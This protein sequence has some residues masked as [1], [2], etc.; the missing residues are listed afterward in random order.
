M[1]TK[2][3]GTTGSGKPKGR[4]DGRPRSLLQG[5]D[6]KR[7]YDDVASR[8][9]SGFLWSAKGKSNHGR[10]LAY[11]ARQSA[12]SAWCKSKRA[13]KKTAGIG[14]RSHGVLDK[15]ELTGRRNAQNPQRSSSRFSLP[16]RCRHCH[17]LCR[18]SLA[19]Q[20]RVHRASLPASGRV[21]A[22]KSGAIVSS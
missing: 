21:A 16:P 18:S 11:I 2:D 19:W 1:R 15:A 22:P 13:K 6:D 20:V 4:P 3:H 9:V 17:R 14:S 5:Q 12:I 8:T 10:Q 7:A